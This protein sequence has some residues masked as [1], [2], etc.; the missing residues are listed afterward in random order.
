MLCSEE[1]RIDCK[2][3][4]ALNLGLGI[5][6]GMLTFLIILVI[7]CAIKRAITMRAL[8]EVLSRQVASDAEQAHQTQDNILPIEQGR[9]SIQRSRIEH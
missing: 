8:R 1:N 2:A 3:R 5:G 4:E 9:T 6:L 7:I